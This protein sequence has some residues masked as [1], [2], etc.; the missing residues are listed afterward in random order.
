VSEVWKSFLEAVRRHGSGPTSVENV[1]VYAN[2]LK[3]ADHLTNLNYS[4]V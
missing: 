4:F 1:I 3:M 2:D